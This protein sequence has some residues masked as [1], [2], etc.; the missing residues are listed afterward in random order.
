MLM[1]KLAKCRPNSMPEHSVLLG[2]ARESQSNIHQIKGRLT[3]IETCKVV[4]TDA[5]APYT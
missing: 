1:Q 2:N 5:H 3:F 4:S